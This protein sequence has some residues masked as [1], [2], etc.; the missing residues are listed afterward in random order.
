MTTKKPTRAEKK[1][2]KQGEM[3]KPSKSAGRL[4]TKYYEF[5]QNNSGGSFHKPAVVVYVEALDAK[6]ANSR[7]EELGIYF[8]GV[9]QGSDCSC[10]GDRWHAADEYYSSDTEPTEYV[11]EYSGWGTEKVPEAVKYRLGEEHPIL[12]PVRKVERK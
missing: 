7:A 12:L 1:H 2:L 9:E 5:R 4:K 11:L 3:D 10:C 6:H 8:D